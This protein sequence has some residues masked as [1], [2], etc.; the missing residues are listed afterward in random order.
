MSRLHL[1][2]VSYIHLLRFHLLMAQPGLES[3]V[4]KEVTDTFPFLVTNSIIRPWNCLGY[5]GISK[6]RR[7]IS[8][9]LSTIGQTSSY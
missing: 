4:T 1:A 9:L 6:P 2:I 3:V 7:R 8:C 5:V